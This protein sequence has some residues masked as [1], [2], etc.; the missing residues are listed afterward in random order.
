MLAGYSYSLIIVLGI[1][2]G[3]QNATARKLDVP[4]LTTTVFTRTIVGIPADSRVVGGSGSKA[5]RRI[6][7]MLAI[8][9]GAIV[10]SL[11]ILYVSRI[12]PLVIALIIMAIIS[13]TVRVLS[14][15]DPSWVRANSSEE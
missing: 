15:T 2:M 3:T 11:L 13:V 12:Y 4:D 5:G 6:I 1:A 7:P 8:L 10:G 14:R 9:V